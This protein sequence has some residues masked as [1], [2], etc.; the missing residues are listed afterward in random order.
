MIRELTLIEKLEACIEIIDESA[1]D[2]YYEFL[3]E[4]L[5]EAILKLTPE[6]LD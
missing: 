4:T 1:I 2:S 6:E 5:Q 3:V